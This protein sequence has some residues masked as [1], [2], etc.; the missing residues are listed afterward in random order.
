MTSPEDKGG[1]PARAGARDL[2]TGS[3]P[4]HLVAFALPM[5]AGNFLQ[6]AFS[7]VNG[8]WVGKRLG[9]DAL[10]A[11]TVSQPVVFVFIA[12]AAG[13]TLGANILVAQDAGAKDWARL[14]RVVQTSY[15]LIGTLSFFFLALGLWNIDGLLSFM[16]TDPGI[17][18]AA[19]GYLRVFLW[20]LPFS[21]WLFLISSVLRGI[22]DSRSPVYFQVA[23]VLINGILDPLLMF[24]WLGFPK[25]G[26]V[27]TAW[28]T[29]IAQGIGVL[30]LLIFVARKRPLVNPDWRHFNFDIPTA[31]LLLFIGF[32][33]MIQQSVVSVS[34]VGIVR[35]VSQ[36]GIPADAAFGAA[37]RIDSVAFMPAITMGMAASTM[38]GQNI[39]VR[40]FNRVRQT[41]GWGAL[42]SVGI[43]ALIMLV[44]MLAPQVLLRAFVS[45]PRVLEIGSG[46]L[47]I[48]SLTYVLY[49]VMFVSHGIINGAGHTLVTTAISMIALWGIR[50]P[51]A[52][53]LARHTHDVK[54]IWFAMLLSVAIGMVLSVS[55]YLTG[56][57]KHAISNTPRASVVTAME[58]EPIDN[59]ES[60]A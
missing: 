5:L 17:Y 45:D 30:G 36:F 58:P 4:R 12:M 15:V 7:L 38:A 24:G 6:V 59:G 47:R 28:A 19:A 11:V 37:L 42:M 53:Y 57:W 49:A 44:A 55:Y 32:P 54:G 8:F 3:I 22:G 23:A 50:L 16:H 41:F 27:G 34:M 40:C 18:R 43:S 52:G 48:V 1:A 51:L 39:G 29:L 21:F 33:S 46:Y 9:P 60:D 26:L 31:G 10:A 13:L 20:T 56:L 2:T 14:Q 35:Y 25:L